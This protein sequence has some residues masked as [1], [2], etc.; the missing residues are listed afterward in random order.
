MR[1][2]VALALAGVVAMMAAE[3]PV[4]EISNGTIRATV[5]LPDPVNGFYRGT[6]FGWS[7][8]VRSI[9]A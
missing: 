5:Y 6:R 2:I 3:P 4:V 9:G 7:G 8:V 1:A